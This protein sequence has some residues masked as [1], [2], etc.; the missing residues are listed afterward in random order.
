MMSPAS[1]FGIEDEVAYLDRTRLGKIKLNEALD[2]S[3]LSEQECA[4]GCFTVCSVGEICYYKEKNFASL[5]AVNGPFL[6]LMFSWRSRVGQKWGERSGDW[7]EGCVGHCVF[8]DA[9]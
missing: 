1:R 9:W 2:R 7:F 4:V 8:Q 3:P 6:Q 5:I